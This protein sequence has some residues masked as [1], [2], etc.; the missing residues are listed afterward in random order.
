M[1]QSI[2]SRPPFIF[3]TMGDF[4]G[5]SFCF[6][7]EGKYRMSDA[8]R[9]ILEREDG[10]L[11]EIKKGFG[12][13]VLDDEGHITIDMVEVRPIDICCM[14][15]GLIE[16]I[17]KMGFMK[18]F[19]ALLSMQEKPDGPKKEFVEPGIEEIEDIADMKGNAYERA[20]RELLEGNMQNEE[21]RENQSIREE[22]NGS[23]L[24]KV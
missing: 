2:S 22:E 5:G 3:Y 4:Y 12:I 7:K 18:E 1:T 9:I 16:V 11:H 8:R 20:D 13:E 21:V 14:T 15:I 23:S 19:Q 10:T 6:L 24:E 17:Q